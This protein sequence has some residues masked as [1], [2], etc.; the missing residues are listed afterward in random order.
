MNRKNK[1]YYLST[2]YRNFIGVALKMFF[3][4]LL[5]PL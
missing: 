4:Q 1:F 5:H 3:K 2:Y